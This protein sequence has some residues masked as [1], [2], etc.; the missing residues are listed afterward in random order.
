MQFFSASEAPIEQLLD[1]VGAAPNRGVRVAKPPEK[2]SPG[3]HL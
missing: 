1:S 3:E 2:F